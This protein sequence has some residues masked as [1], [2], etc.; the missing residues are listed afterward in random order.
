MNKI[1]SAKSKNIVSSFSSF[2]RGMSLSRKLLIPILTII[3]LIAIGLVSYT[4]YSNSQRS[5]ADE[6]KGLESIQSA[7]LSQIDGLSN[8]ALGLATEMANN[9]E[10][11]AAFAS[12]DR[13]HLTDITLPT[14]QVVQKEFAVKQY[15]FILPPATSFLRLH[16]L[17]KFGDDL[18]SIRATTVKAN[19]EKIAVSGTEIGRGGLGV[20]GEAPL[21]YQGRHIGVVDV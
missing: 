3:I 17:D 21:A 6:A 2:W 9:P 18:T 20:R 16:Q 4:F 19:T 15:Q 14:F 7:V 10:A 13:Q 11:Q 1:S 8:L 12:G 5:H